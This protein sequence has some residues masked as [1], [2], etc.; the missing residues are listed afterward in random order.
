MLQVDPTLDRST[1]FPIAT[2][3]TAAEHIFDISRFYDN[4]DDSELSDK[5]DS[6]DESD[7]SSDS[8]SDNSS[9]GDGDSEYGK[10][11]KKSLSKTKK[12]KVKTRKSKSLVD[13]YSGKSKSK[14]SSTLATPTSK[15]SV[16]DDTDEVADLINKLGRLSLNDPSYAS[17]YFLIVSKAPKNKAMEYSDEQVEVQDDREINAG[18][19]N[20]T[21]VYLVLRPHDDRKAKRRS[22]LLPPVTSMLPQSGPKPILKPTASPPAPTPVQY[23]PNP[24]A[25]T[26]PPTDQKMP[27]IIPYDTMIL[28]FDPEDEDEIME[29]AFS[30]QG[31]TTEP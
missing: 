12:S 2:V 6:D 15:P 28:P 4:T 8:T 7:S 9:E 30:D 22:M 26:A 18:M 16:P 21:E 19:V 27:T 20:A 1:P 10:G 17:L 13:K 31:E 23:R 24:P 14:S 29:D 11:L 25:A 3:I 5:E